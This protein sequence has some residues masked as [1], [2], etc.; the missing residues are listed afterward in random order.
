[1][2]SKIQNPMDLLQNV[3][4]LKLLT[5]IYKVK[6]HS[7]LTYLLISYR[8]GFHDWLNGI[9]TAVSQARTG[10]MGC[11]QQFF[12]AWRDVYNSISGA[13]WFNGMSTTIFRAHRDVYNSISGA[14]W[15]NG[16]STTTFQSSTRCL[17]LS[18]ART[19][20]MRCL[21]QSFRAQRDVYNS[22]SGADWFSIFSKSW[23][24]YEFKTKICDA[25]DSK[26]C[27]VKTPF[28][29]Q[30]TMI[31]EV[32]RKAVSFHP[33]NFILNQSIPTILLLSIP[34]TFVFIRVLTRNPLR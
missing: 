11:L 24:D 8:C 19:G 21:Q 34:T 3:Y 18:Q 2:K 1:M 16:M 6:L 29:C 9:S 31:W 4:K 28:F 25:M 14:D 33:N 12:R 15:F 23:T 20:S 7:N 13:D 30:F 17:Q 27:S 10:S 32:S 22:I 26:Q 5:D